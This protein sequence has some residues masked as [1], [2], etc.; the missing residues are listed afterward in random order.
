MQRTCCSV[1]F[2]GRLRGCRLRGSLLLV[3]RRWRWR[4]RWRFVGRRDLEL[5]MELRTMV[6]ANKSVSRSVVSLALGRASSVLS[7]A[8]LALQSV[9]MA[10]LDFVLLHRAEHGLEWTVAA[11]EQRGLAEGCG[12]VA[13]AAHGQV[14][15]R[16]GVDTRDAGGLGVVSVRAGSVA[17]G[18]EHLGPSV[19]VS[20]AMLRP[21]VLESMEDV[22]T[23]VSMADRHVFG[24]LRTAAHGWQSTGPWTC[25]FMGATWPSCTAR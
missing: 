14:S 13:V 11:V 23:V 3:S 7:G 20:V 22:A 10:V 15:G 5:S 9:I 8:R 24:D 6:F 1:W 19:A 2:S 12:G 21:I 16:E 4:T 18:S 25:T 17:R